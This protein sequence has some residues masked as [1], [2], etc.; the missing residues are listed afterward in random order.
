[1]PLDLRAKRDRLELEV[2]ILRDSKEKLAEDE[3][4]SK[5]EALLCDIARIY[6]QTSSIGTNY[7]PR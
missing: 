3:Y 5:L 1:M 6:E 7:N 4:F 2:M